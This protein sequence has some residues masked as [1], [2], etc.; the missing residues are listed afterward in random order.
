MSKHDIYSALSK[1]HGACTVSMGCPPTP[2]SSFS[3]MTILPAIIWGIG[4][5]ILP[6]LELA[7]LQTLY[8]CVVKHSARAVKVRL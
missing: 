3:G 8:S 4:Y 2:S 6:T 5:N 7:G 1:L